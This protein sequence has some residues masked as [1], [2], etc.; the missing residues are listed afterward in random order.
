MSFEMRGE[1]FNIFN[2]TEFNNPDS[3][4]AVAPQVK[5]STTG[6]PTSG[7]GRVSPRSD[8]DSQNEA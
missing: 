5:D 1:F 7:F 4:N 2:R 6:I 3:T 8:A